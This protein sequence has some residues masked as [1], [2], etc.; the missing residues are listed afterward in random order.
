MI[1][2]RIRGD[3]WPY[4]I[5]GLLPEPYTLKML[6][7]SPRRLEQPQIRASSSDLFAEKSG[8][9]WRTGVS[10]SISS[11][12]R[13]MHVTHFAF[14][15]PRPK[16]SWAQLPPSTAPTHWWGR[17]DQVSDPSPWWLLC[18]RPSI[19]MQLCSESCSSQSLPGVLRVSFQLAGPTP[20][21]RGL[22]L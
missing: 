16:V 6:I 7:Q 9:A 14:A 11:A 4:Q 2:L 17:Q 12:R 8:R 3:N 13:K 5:Q 1:E 21:P 10:I 19:L 15:G 18:M 22:Q 20:S